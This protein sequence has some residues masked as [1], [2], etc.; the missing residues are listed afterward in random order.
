MRYCTYDTNCTAIRNSYM[1]SE[2]NEQLK[3]ENEQLKQENENLKQENKS[4]AKR[5]CEL[6]GDLSKV[7]WQI[8]KNETNK[9]V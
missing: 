9:C 8:E 7:K 4:L 6:Q 2:E 1:L 5:V 3:K